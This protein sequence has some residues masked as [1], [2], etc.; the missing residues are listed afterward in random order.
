M[1][2]FSLQ[3]S[4][5]SH[6]EDLEISKVWT[7]SDSKRNY[8]CFVHKYQFKSGVYDIRKKSRRDYTHLQCEKLYISK[9]KGHTL[10]DQMYGGR[11]L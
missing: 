6:A 7:L 11:E 10:A 4:V 9:Q 1:D 8:R 3:H 2:T 5:F